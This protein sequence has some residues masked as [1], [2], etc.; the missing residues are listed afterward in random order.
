MS[1]TEK[2]HSSFYPNCILEWN[3]LDPEIILAPSVTVF[4]KKLLSI[5]RPAAKSVFGIHDPLGLSYLSQLR[6]GLGKLNFHKFT[7]NFKDTWY[8]HCVQLMMELRIRNTFCCSVRNLIFN[9][10]IFSLIFRSC[11]NHLSR[12]TTQIFF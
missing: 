8:P 10:V 5:I 6:V 11:Y 7:H 4:K 9:D 3:T 1:R 12:S 2:F